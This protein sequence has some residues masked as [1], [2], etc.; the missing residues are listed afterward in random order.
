M[1]LT[2]EDQLEIQQLYA[3]YNHAID[4]GNGDG[5]AAC[6]TPEGKFSS[7]T[8]TFNGTTELTNFARGF[9]ERIKGRHWTN[10]LLIEGEGE[11][12]SGRCYLIL[13]RLGD[14]ENPATPLT[15]GIYEDT[16]VKTIDGWRFAERKVNGDN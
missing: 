6:F 14:R 4:S 2:V 9:A 16:L 5:W 13:Y 12:A 7:A 3:R 11:H 8:G 1:P 10:N 15:T